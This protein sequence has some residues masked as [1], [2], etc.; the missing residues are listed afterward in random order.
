MT[1]ETVRRLPDWARRLD[2][3]VDAHRHAGFDWRAHNCCT[4]AAG[5]V[6]AMTGAAP[7]LPG[8]AAAG[9]W[10]AMRWLHRAGGLAAAVDAALPRLAAPALARRGDVVLLQHG[11]RQ[12]LAVHLGHLWAAPARGGMAFGPAA[13][14]VAAWG[15]GRA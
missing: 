3:Y 1:A 8:C 2:A 4:F 5:A 10:P 11:R 13:Q 6:A 14:A 9:A 12:L 7:A 15:V